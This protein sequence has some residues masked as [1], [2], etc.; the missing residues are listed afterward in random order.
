VNITKYSFLLEYQL[1]D[2]DLMSTKTVCQA[3]IRQL[4]MLMRLPDLA[5]ENLDTNHITK[6]NKI[7]TSMV[8]NETTTVGNECKLSINFLSLIFII[9]LLE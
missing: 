2:Y 4:E 6:T 3:L 8:T 5:A 7:N 1:R 9:Y